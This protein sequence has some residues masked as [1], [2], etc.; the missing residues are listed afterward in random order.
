MQLG[1][2]EI[3]YAY[4]QLTDRCFFKFPVDVLLQDNTLLPGHS[5]HFTL[6]FLSS[7]LTTEKYNSYAGQ[8][9][10]SDFVL[11]LLE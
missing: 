7:A 3:K 10:F 2:K 8:G 6:K 9:S 1:T 11:I 5:S 4:S